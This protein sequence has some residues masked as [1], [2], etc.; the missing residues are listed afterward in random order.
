MNLWE[1]DS[2]NMDACFVRFFHDD[3]I[4]NI[5]LKVITYFLSHVFTI[6]AT[7]KIQNDIFFENKGQQQELT[8][9]RASTYLEK[10]FLSKATTELLLHLLG[11]NW[12]PK[13]VV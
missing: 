9:G 12:M 2:I 5:P 11:V 4:S 8:L 13:Y 7:N 3:F 1:G 10:N 6:Q